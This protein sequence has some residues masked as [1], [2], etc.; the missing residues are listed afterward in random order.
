MQSRPVTDAEKLL[1]DRIAQLG[2]ICCRMEGK[3][4]NPHVSIHHAHGRMKPGAHMWVLALCEPHHQDNGTAVARHPW[5]RRWE[6]KFGKEDDLIRKQWEDLGVEFKE[7]ER[8]AKPINRDRPAKAVKNPKEKAETAEAPAAKISTRA[9]ATP[10]VKPAK[11]ESQ[12]AYEAEQ[13]RL[14]AARTAEFREKSKAQGEADKPKSVWPTRP[15]KSKS[16]TASKIPS[17]AAKVKVPKSAK[18]IAYNEERK[19]SQKRFLDERKPDMK[20][21]AKAQ[22][23]AYEEA[24]KDQIGARKQKAKDDQKKFKADL[25]AKRKQAK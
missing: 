12:I 21:Q 14:Q 10:R 13:K 8:K 19:A 5:K 20:A 22:R 25:A 23:L 7:P 17:R 24:N 18:E 1:H 9:P 2:C 6:A 11:T 3:G 16:A 15:A 4:L